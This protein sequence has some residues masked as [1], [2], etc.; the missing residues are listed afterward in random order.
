M[1]KNYII[2]AIKAELGEGYDVEIKTV[3]KTNGVTYTGASIRKS[4]DN[5]SPMIYCNDGDTD[6]EIVTKTLEAYKACE[7]DPFN[8]NVND[9]TNWN[10]VKDKVIPVLVNSGKNDLD[11]TP[12]V[13]LTSDIAVVF[14][15]VIPGQNKGGIG[16]VLI[17][18]DLLASW[19]VD[20]N[21]LYDYARENIDKTV[22]L[23]NMSHIID[24]MML[25]V[26]EDKARH[27]STINEPMA[28]MTTIS[29][30]NGAG[31][32]TIIPDLI[33]SGE[34]PKQDYIIIPSSIHEC[35]L[36]KDL[37][38]MG[39][40]EINSMIRDVNST[41]VS[42]AEFLSNYAFMYKASTRSFETLKTA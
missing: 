36:I 20:V 11:K 16:T 30:T 12:H 3:T 27:I 35:L 17:S 2:N 41:Q 29:K 23:D 39:A 7:T 37:E 8:V 40:D 22:T 14:R 5:I 25:G 26:E 6:E 10:W 28:V 1:D 21:T 42:D 19:D 32:I 38:R 4:G 13:I 9:F 24:V 31:A 15:I 34:L 18:N 33:E